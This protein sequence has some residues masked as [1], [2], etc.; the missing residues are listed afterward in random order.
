MKRI[1]RFIFSGGLAA[2]TEYAIYL[3]LF[4]GLGSHVVFAQAFSF[5]GG[6]VVSYLMNKFWVFSDTK[7]A[8]YKKEFALFALLGGT[9]LVVTSLLIQ[10]LVGGL[11]IYAPVAKLALM[12]CVA[13][14]NYIIFQKIIFRKK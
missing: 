11:H 14:W 6:L 10:V 9:N 5:C 2:L 1:V 4:F 13:T 12:A 8:E 7:R 3:L